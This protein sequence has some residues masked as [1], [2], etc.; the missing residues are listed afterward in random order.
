MRANR[1]PPA[2]I[3]AMDIQY[4]LSALVPF[5]A[6]TIT[7]DPGFSADEA[8]ERFAWL[9]GYC[10]APARLCYEVMRVARPPSPAFALFAP[11]GDG[12]PYIDARPQSGETC[13]RAPD[14]CC[15]HRHARAERGGLVA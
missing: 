13:A 15:V 11:T 14:L 5:G 7:L 12:A 3:A 6:I 10:R 1:R 8:A 9:L 2:R 4:E